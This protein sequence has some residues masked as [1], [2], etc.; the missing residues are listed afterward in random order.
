MATDWGE[1][2]FIP[3]RGLD[4][5]VV[6]QALAQ[7]EPD[8]LGFELQV[9]TS[10]HPRAKVTAVVVQLGP[11]EAIGLL[12]GV[13]RRLA[14]ALRQPTYSFSLLAGVESWM[15]V[16]AF[17]ARGRQSW[18]CESSGKRL[19]AKA[20]ADLRRR[21]RGPKLEIDPVEW[22]YWRMAAELPTRPRRALLPLGT[23]Q[24]LDLRGCPGWRRL[25]ITDLRFSAA[26]AAR[27]VEA[28]RTAA[29]ARAKRDA[30][31]AVDQAAALQARIEHEAAQKVMREAEERVLMDRTLALGVTREVLLPAAQHTVVEK[32]ASKYGVQ[33]EWVW[34]A[35]AARSTPWKFP[36]PALPAC[37]NRSPK[38]VALVV[39]PAL[40]KALAQ[41]SLSRADGTAASFE[42]L[43][44]V[45]ISVGLDELKD[46]LK[47]DQRRRLRAAK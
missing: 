45:A 15:A 46:D 26:H 23:T 20:L 43:V 7:L 39:S 3:T 38:P 14:R 19:A 25:A 47:E 29:A 1:A 36:A 11:E 31:A 5:A 9:E 22:P 41:S 42:E 10:E 6:D 27:L 17:D 37:P 24:A 2:I 44:R 40:E 33:P 4:R 30:Q 18:R 32:L 21:L 34:Q 35:A 16:T 8:R 28:E 13:A 12:D